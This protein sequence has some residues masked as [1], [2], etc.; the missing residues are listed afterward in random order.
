M[1]THARRE[2]GFW[3]KKQIMVNKIKIRLSI[4]S[5]NIQDALLISTKN[6]I[7]TEVLG[8]ISI[9][10]ADSVKLI[11]ITRLNKSK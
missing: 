6:H 7:V 9:K 1:G 11:N 2:Y 10:L 8:L 4:K 3:N 5:L